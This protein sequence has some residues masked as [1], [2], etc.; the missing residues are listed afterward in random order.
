M[1]R[2]RAALLYAFAAISMF[3]IF[4]LAATPAAA[5]VCGNGAVEAGEECDDGNTLPGDCCSA[6]CQFEA[7]PGTSPCCDDGVCLVG[8][9]CGTVCFA[10][11]E[12]SLDA[13]L[14]R[15]TT[16]VGDCGMLGPGIC[17]G[18]CPS[19]QVCVHV[20]FG[21]APGECF[22]AD[23]PACAPNLCGGNCPPEGPI[24]FAFPEG[25]GCLGL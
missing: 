17:A 14:C 12:C 5:Q 2:L 1:R 23:E 15:C 6:T 9:N 21:P 7:G 11:S 22:C 20:N 25:C 8:Q 4:G 16:P 24:C 13:D 3:L 10:Q 19:G 18:A